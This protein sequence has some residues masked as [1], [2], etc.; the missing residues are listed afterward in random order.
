MIWTLKKVNCFILRF[1]KHQLKLA[2]YLFKLGGVFSMKTCVKPF[3]QMWF[4][5]D[6]CFQVGSADAL[7]FFLPGVAS[8]LVKSV[9]SSKKMNSGMSELSYPSGAAGSSL[10]VEQALRALNEL[11]V[12]VLADERNL[13]AVRRDKNSNN[14][15]VKPLIGHESGETALSMLH[16]ERIRKN[17]Q[18]INDKQTMQPEMNE[19]NFQG[20]TSESRKTDPVLPDDTEGVGKLR[21]ERSEAWLEYTNKRISSL[22]SLCYPAVSVSSIQGFLS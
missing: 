11:I 14:L 19:C 3:P 13:N 6:H 4:M 16:T 5:C 9:Q 15:T 18:S 20:I 8:R 2:I 1:V 22:L 21:V 10:A 17:M 12:L 7:A